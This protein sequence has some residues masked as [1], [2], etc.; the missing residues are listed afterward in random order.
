MTGSD[1]RVA[2]RLVTQGRAPGSFRQ[3]LW[4]LLAAAVVSAAFQ[5]AAFP[6][7]AL[8]PLAWIALVPLLWALARCTVLGGLGLGLA[9]SL[10]VG[11]FTSWWL[12]SMIA[13][14]FGTGSAGG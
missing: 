11:A 12:P 14:Y 1:S 7:L 9:W 10:A 2:S 6:P 3:S 5:A 13:D 8:F 4:A